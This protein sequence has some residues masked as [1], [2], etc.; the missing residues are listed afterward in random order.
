LT[1]IRSGI[2]LFEMFGTHFREL[3]MRMPQVA[4]MRASPAPS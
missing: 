1:A 4:Q 2:A 3:E